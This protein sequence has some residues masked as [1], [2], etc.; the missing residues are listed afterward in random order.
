MGNRAI[1]KPVDKN[2]GVYLHWNGGRDS[3]EAFL[4]YCKLRGFRDFGGEHA[5]GYGIARFI[6]VVTNFFGGSL[7]V[8][9]E[10]GVEMTNEQAEWLDNGIYEINGWEIV[11]RCPAGITEQREYDMNEMLV[12]IDESQPE[13]DR[14]GEGY[15]RAKE[16]PVSEL[17][18]GDSV[19]IY[20]DFAYGDEPKCKA[21]EI[22]GIGKRGKFVNGTR[23]AGIPYVNRFPSLGEDNINNYLTGKN[24][25]AIIGERG[26]ND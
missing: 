2:I 13:T 18:I 10:T 14:L 15:L 11:G 21:W 24:Y 3:V 9:V 17:K 19:Y 16:V 20:N 8:G 26:S 6:Q 1:I 23:V 7:C 12:T 22:V 5:D 4:E 25:R